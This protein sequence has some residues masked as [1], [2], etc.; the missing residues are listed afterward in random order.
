MSDLDSKLDSK[1]EHTTGRFSSWNAAVSRQLKAVPYLWIVFLF[2]ALGIV[3]LYLREADERGKQGEQFRASL[4]RL[5]KTDHECR[6][7]ALPAQHPHP[8]DIG[9][10]KHHVHECFEQNKKL[11]DEY[12]N[13]IINQ[14][15]IK[16]GND[17]K[18]E[19]DTKID[20]RFDELR[21]QIESSTANAEAGKDLILR[22]FRGESGSG[23]DTSGGM[24]AVLNSSTT[25]GSVPRVELVP[26]PVPGKP[27]LPPPLPGEL[28]CLVNL[29]P[30]GVK[31]G[32]C[33]TP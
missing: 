7:G 14:V 16:V 20:A 15:A 12:V 8:K 26:I 23:T 27:G 3:L 33:Q 18:M 25:S 9:Y 24:N 10:E 4:T 32:V 5:E 11:A 19:V 17:V 2:V 30:L 29:S 22:V 6:V 21:K 13:N 28:R 1:K 31:V